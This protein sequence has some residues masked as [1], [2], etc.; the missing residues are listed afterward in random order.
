MALRNPSLYELEHERRKHPRVAFG[1]RAKISP[2]FDGGNR[3][4]SVMLRD[5]SKAGVGFL[6]SKRL[7]SSDEFVLHLRSKS[8]KPIYIHC[9]VAHCDIGG[10]G[11]VQYVIV[12][13]SSR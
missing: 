8:N 5:I 1:S 7:D 11:C 2:L 4:V 3:G 9:M 13:L 12:Q 10:T 6:S